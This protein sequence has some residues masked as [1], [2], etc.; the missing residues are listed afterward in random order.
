MSWTETTR[1]KYR[2][3]SPRYESDLTDAEWRRIA[4]ALPVSAQRGRPRC[5]ELR[6]VINALFYQLMTGC[7]WRALPRCFPAVP[8]VRYYF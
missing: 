2:R 3:Q 5:V 7:P 4:P 6:E 1:E 8:T